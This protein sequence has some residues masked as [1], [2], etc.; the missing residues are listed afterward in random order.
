MRARLVV[1]CSALLVVL[2]LWMVGGG[3][4]QISAQEAPPAK[5]HFLEVGKKYHFEYALVRAQV[6]ILEEPRDQWVKALEDEDKPRQVW[7]NLNQVHF[8]EAR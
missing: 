7:I 5:R 4:K 8:I 6:T 3:S 1:A 2:A